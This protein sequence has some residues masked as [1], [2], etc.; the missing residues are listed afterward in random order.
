MGK[1]AIK[2][3]MD[4]RYRDYSVE[5]PLTQAQM[6]EALKRLRRMIPVGPK[7]QVNVDETIRLPRITLVKL[8]SCLTGVFATMP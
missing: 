3:A 8:K 6:G 4:R 2:V 1:S 5:G 7:D